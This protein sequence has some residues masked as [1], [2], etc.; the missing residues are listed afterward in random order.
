MQPSRVTSARVTRALEDAALSTSQTMQRPPQASLASANISHSRECVQLLSCRAAAQPSA[1]PAKD[2]STT[3]SS[4]SSPHPPPSATTDAV[5]AACGVTQR[6]TID[7]HAASIRAEG[8]VLAQKQQQPVQIGG[9]LHLRERKTKRAREQIGSMLDLQMH[10]TP[11]RAETNAPQQHAETNSLQMQLGS[12]AVQ[13]NQMHDT[14]G[15]AVAHASEAE[16]AENAVVEAELDKTHNLQSA[17]P[18]SPPLP[19]PACPPPQYPLSH[20]PGHPPWP[21]SPRLNSPPLTPPFPAPHPPFSHV[22]PAISSSN[23]LLP[24]DLD[25]LPPPSAATASI[26]RHPLSASTAC[27]LPP[28]LSTSTASPKPSVDDASKVLQLV[29]AHSSCSPQPVKPVKGVANVERDGDKLGSIDEM[30]GIETNKQKT[31]Q[32]EVP[33]QKQDTMSSEVK[34][35]EHSN[36]RNSQRGGGLETES[37]EEFMDADFLAALNLLEEAAA[38]RCTGGGTGKQGADESRQEIAGNQLHDSKNGKDR[39]CRSDGGGGGGRVWRVHPTPEIWRQGMLGAV[40]YSKPAVHSLPPPTLIPLDYEAAHESLHNRWM[41]GTRRSVLK[42]TLLAVAHQH[43]REWG[44]ENGTSNDNMFMWQRAVVVRDVAPVG[45][46]PWK[47]PVKMISDHNSSEASLCANLSVLDSMDRSMDESHDMRMSALPER[48]RSLN[49]SDLR[50][51]LDEELTQAEEREREGR[52]G[53][54]ATATPAA[55]DGG[56]ATAATA[57]G[58]DS[59]RDSAT[60]AATLRSEHKLIDSKDLHLLQVES[61]QVDFRDVLVAEQGACLLDY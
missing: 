29:P 14:V 5:T 10:H 19:P 1:H 37:E 7:E 20:S 36:A 11:S 38:G 54:T 28:P 34:K 39:K 57:P 8:L 47:V 26:L 53:G 50:N 55:R 44:A 45:P 61:L 31:C 49:Q 41:G 16:N 15:H 3:A 18:D 30:A 59:G 51:I 4:S 12:N 25:A 52:D 17:P 9:M 56:T 43:S 46:P 60:P 23:P 22:A 13:Q 32:V 42:G 40:G 33:A 48:E 6:A 35:E 27:P 2:E 58:K 21:Q 24:F